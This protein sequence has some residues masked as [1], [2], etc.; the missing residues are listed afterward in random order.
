MKLYNFTRQVEEIAREI[1]NRLNFEF[2]IEKVN[3]S[4]FEDD[5][6][7][8]HISVE[9]NE[10]LVHAYVFVHIIDEKIEYDICSTTI[11]FP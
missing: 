4:F 10:D 8:Y 1:A 11:F 5:S 2:D 3:V 9:Y 7:D 6:Y